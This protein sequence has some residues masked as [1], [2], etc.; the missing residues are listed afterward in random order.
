MYDLITI[1]KGMID[2][3]DEL[4]DHAQRHIT[5][6]CTGELIVSLAGDE[7]EYSRR[8][9]LDHATS[10]TRDRIP[11][12]KEKDPAVIRY[13]ESAF[14][15]AQ[16]EALKK[17]RKAL[18]SL[19]SGYRA[20]DPETIRNSLPPNYRTLPPACYEDPR[21]RALVEWANESYPA[22]SREFPKHA[23]VTEDGQKVRSMGEYMIYS[24][25]RAA[26]IPFRYEAKLELTAPDGHLVWRCPDFTFMTI[27]G[28]PLYWEH[29]GKLDDPD[30]MEVNLEKLKLYFLNGLIPGR[31]LILTADSGD[32]RITPAEIEAVIRTRVLPLIAA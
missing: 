17:S 28:L 3:I 1:A 11:L 12:G 24:A 6:E 23:L 29:L 19:V 32:Q 9:Y 4:I 20:F 30:Y 13:K 18:A 7:P 2:W 27:L 14:Y 15:A 25:L 21:F 5:M 26:G 10:R 31:N 22:N 8:I 16:L